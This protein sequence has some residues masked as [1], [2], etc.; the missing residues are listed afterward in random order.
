MHKLSRLQIVLFLLSFLFSELFA[1]TNPHGKYFKIDCN[2]CHNSGS[3]QIASDNK[4]F[5]HFKETGFELEGQHKKLECNRCHQDLSFKGLGNQ[6]MDCH[7]D[8]HQTSV[9]NDCKRC[10]NSE[11][12]FVQ[13][14]ADIHSENGFFLEGAHVAVSCIDCHKNNNSQ[15]WSRMTGQCISCHTTDYQNTKNPNHIQAGYSTDC[16]E[17]HSPQSAVWKSDFFHYFFPLSQGHSGLTCVQCH[18]NKPYNQVSS[19]C[20]SCHQN[21]YNSATDPNHKQSG[22]PTDC[23]KCHT[24]QVGWSPAKY[25]DH[26]AD[27]FPIYSGNHKGAWTKCTDCHNN[28]S[29][30]SSFSCIDCHEH[31]DQ[32]DLTDEHKDVRNFVFQSKACFECHPRGSE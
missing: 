24:T 26:D 15:V 1:Q 9:G 31:S 30:F 17:C 13:N 28:S 16:I 5:D 10:H 18:Q 32:A 21:D 3:W 8:I 11:N 23:A 19:D 22:F 2:Q 14:I 20:I 6:C 25:D 29:N 12:W 4:K 7:T 27:F